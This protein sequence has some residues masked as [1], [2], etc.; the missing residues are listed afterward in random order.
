MYR[1]ED[2]LEIYN[3][4]CYTGKYSLNSY[5]SLNEGCFCLNIKRRIG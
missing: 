5:C 3:S 2:L 1:V 4:G